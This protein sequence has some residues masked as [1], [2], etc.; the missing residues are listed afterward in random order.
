MVRYSTCRQVAQPKG[1]MEAGK[2]G[3]FQSS[4]AAVEKLWLGKEKAFVWRFNY[5]HDTSVLT[6]AEGG[7]VFPFKQQQKGKVSTSLFSG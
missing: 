7:E 2:K 4:Q 1:Y 3:S 6:K 5:M